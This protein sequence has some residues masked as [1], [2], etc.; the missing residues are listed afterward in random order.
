MTLQ[1]CSYNLGAYYVVRH[2]VEWFC[3]STIAPALTHLMQTKQGEGIAHCRSLLRTCHD[4]A[5]IGKSS[6]YT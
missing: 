5:P 3:V 6:P 4:S 2:Y 1:I